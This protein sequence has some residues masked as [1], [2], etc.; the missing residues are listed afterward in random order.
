MKV[1][2]PTAISTHHFRS[3]FKKER[4]PYLASTWDV[5]GW[6]LCDMG[7]SFELGPGTHLAA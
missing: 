2:V 4:A 6:D 3:I 1:P 7:L 5:G